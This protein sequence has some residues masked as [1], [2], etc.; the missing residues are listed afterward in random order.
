MIF[1]VFLPRQS[2]SFQDNHSYFDKTKKEVVC[3]EPLP[4]FTLSEK[5]DPTNL[6]VQKLCTCIWNNFP[7]NGWE[8]NTSKSIRNRQDPGWRGR[9]FISRFSGVS[10]DCGG[11]IL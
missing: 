5:S 10:K 9:A 2:L 1:L 3:K 6:Q 11:Y 7:E 8:H 4:I